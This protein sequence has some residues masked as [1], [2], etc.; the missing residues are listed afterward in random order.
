MSDPHPNLLPG[1][2]HCGAV[3]LEFATALT[4]QDTAPR[5]CDCDFCRKHG[6]AY[7]SD[8]TGRLRIRVADA[9]GLLAYR[10]GSEAAL[11]RLCARC[12]VLVAVTYEQDGRLYAAVNATAL[13]R[14]DAFLPA[15]DASPQLLSREQKI[16]R[17][18]RLWVG[19]VAVTGSG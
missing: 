3:R 4:P 19:D 13:D 1:G 2:C 8:P 17:W 5:A 9:A 16:E 11:F 15:V 14:R 18:T 7:V 10:Q 12:G 6:A